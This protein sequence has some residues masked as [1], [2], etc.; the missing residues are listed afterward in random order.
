MG[1]LDPSARRL[2]AGELG[3]V[4][5]PGRGMLGSSLTH[6]GEEL[7]GRIDDLERAATTGAVAGIPLLHPWANRLAGLRYEAA[8]RAVEL[9]PASPLLH[10]DANGLPIHGVPWSRLAFGVT[11]ER[12]DA[13]SARLEWAT[14]ELLAVF[15]FPHLLELDVTLDPDGLTIETALTPAADAPVPVSFGFHPYFAPPG[16]A[17][18]DWV[19]TLPAMERLELDSRGIPTGARAPVAPSSAPLGVRLL[20]DGFASP[21]PPRLELSGGGRRIGVELGPGYSFAQVF[22]PASPAVVAL[23][24]MTAPTNA[25]A[26]G[27]D[28][29][30]VE[31]GDSFVASFRIGIS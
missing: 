7:L 6:R 4:F 3:A 22:A 26:S 25:L 23:E 30:Y 10:L 31:P 21:A 13:L 16:A 8:G 12:E 27:A 28:L 19:L 17:R 18:G 11:A 14:R 20:D 29:Q 1:V 5:L 15:P 9:D 2:A 24:P